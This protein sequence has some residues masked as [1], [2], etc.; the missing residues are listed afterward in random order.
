MSKN[1]THLYCDWSFPPT[2]GDLNFCSKILIILMKSIKFTCKE[3]KGN[4]DFW[5]LHS[6]CSAKECLSSQTNQLSR[7]C[8]VHPARTHRDL[9]CQTYCLFYQCTSAWPPLPVWLAKAFQSPSSEKCSPSKIPAE[10]RFPSRTGHWIWFGATEHCPKLSCGFM[11]ES[12]KENVSPIYSFDPLF[13][14]T[15]TFNIFCLD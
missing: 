9:D 4:G 6:I 7:G 3:N 15:L 2:S 11:T 5:C 8:C 10:D 13:S 12:P 14:L 1:M